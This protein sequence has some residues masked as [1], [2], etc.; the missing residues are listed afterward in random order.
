MKIRIV[1]AVMLATSSLPCMSEIT[2]SVDSEGNVT[3]SDQPVAGSVDATPVII[4]TSSAPSKQEIT[5][6]EQQAQDMINRAKKID[7]SNADREAGI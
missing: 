6:S 7:K 1:L 3:F 5:E 4:D 2:R